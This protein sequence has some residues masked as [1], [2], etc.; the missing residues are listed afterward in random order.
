MTYATDDDDN[1]PKRAGETNTTRQVTPNTYVSLVKLQYMSIY[2]QILRQSLPTRLY[3]KTFTFFQKI[4][5]WIIT[6]AFNIINDV[7]NDNA[8]YLRLEIANHLRLG[9]R[10]RFWSGFAFYSEAKSFIHSTFDISQPTFDIWQY[11]VFVSPAI[12]GPTITITTSEIKLLIGFEAKDN[13]FLKKWNVY[14]LNVIHFLF[15]NLLFII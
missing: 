10:L 14:F 13:G 11:A 3:I 12:P 2:G 6:L 8:N 7:D 9:S 15:Y 1:Q 4:F 5:F